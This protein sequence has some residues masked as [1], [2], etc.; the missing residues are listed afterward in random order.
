MAQSPINQQCYSAHCREGESSDGR[1]P[2]LAEA[3]RLVM[4]AEM[5]ERDRLEEAQEKDEKSRP[6][7]TD[8]AGHQHK[9]GLWVLKSHA[10]S[11]YSSSSA[12]I[13]HWLS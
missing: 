13:Y 12:S 9:S 3:E 11:V 10:A 5:E 6:Q 7:E 4:D 1:N 2:D 8:F